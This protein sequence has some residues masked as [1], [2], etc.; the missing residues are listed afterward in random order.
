MQLPPSSV[1]V[2]PSVRPSVRPP[3]TDPAFVR[4]PRGRSVMVVG[5]S[6]TETAAALCSA[7]GLM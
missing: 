1:R 4:K 5:P 3:P 2:R 6:T 7:A